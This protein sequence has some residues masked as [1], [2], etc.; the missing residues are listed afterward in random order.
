MGVVKS[1]VMR[2]VKLK[3]VKKGNGKVTWNCIF[4]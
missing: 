1:I 3:Y 2:R 4:L